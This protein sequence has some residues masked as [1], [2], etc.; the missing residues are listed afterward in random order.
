MSRGRAIPSATRLKLDADARSTAC[1]AAPWNRPTVPRSGARSNVP[2]L[3]RPT[4]PRASVLARRSSRA[5]TDLDVGEGSG[6]G[7]VLR[8]QKQ[9]SPRGAARSVRHAR[10]PAG[11]VLQ[12]TARPSRWHSQAPYSSRSRSS[13]SRLS[14]TGRRGPAV[15]QPSWKA[16]PSRAVQPSRG[17]GPSRAARSSGR[18]GRAGR[19]TQPGEA[20]GQNR[21]S[22]VT[23][24]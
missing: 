18:Q 15:A 10:T 17:T 23:L 19:A 11:G 3:E 6:E 16:S 22:F 4:A 14:P 5:A 1:G 7:S 21:R 9:P 20:T 2:V 8:A 24:S 13:R 12:Q